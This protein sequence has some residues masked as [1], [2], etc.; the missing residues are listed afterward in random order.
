MI[1]NELLTSGAA[2]GAGSLRHAV[3]TAE[4]LV[5]IALDVNEMTGLATIELS[6]PA[7]V[8][9]GVGFNA[10]GQ[11]TRDSKRKKKKGKNNNK[12]KKQK[13]TKK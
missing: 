9:F 8:W 2:C 10:T 4:S 12:N 6:G 5:D 13:Q 11:S 7:S 3:S 1:Y